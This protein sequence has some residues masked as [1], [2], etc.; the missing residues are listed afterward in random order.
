MRQR[1]AQRLLKFMKETGIDQNAAN[2][3][4]LLETSRV[5]VALNILEGMAYGGNRVMNRT[6]SDTLRISSKSVDNAFYALNDVKS[7][8]LKGLI[9]VN[10]GRYN[11]HSNGLAKRG[12]GYTSSYL[13]TT[14]AGRKLYRSI[15]RHG[16]VDMFTS[17]DPEK[18]LLAHGQNRLLRQ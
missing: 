17:E 18:W 8:A 10:A 13:Y 15:K 4:K 5:Q 7:E 2:T 14:R 16:L 12:W 3:L 11:V 6:I 1:Y 9:R